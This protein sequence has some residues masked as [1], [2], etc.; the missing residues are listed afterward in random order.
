MMRATVS[1]PPLGAKPTTMVIGRLGNTP[2]ASAPAAAP[3][4][5]I[6]LRKRIIAAPR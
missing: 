4:A 3:K 2:C 1:V 5:S 6:A